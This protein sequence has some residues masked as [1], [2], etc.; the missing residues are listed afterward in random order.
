MVKKKRVSKLTEQE[1]IKNAKEYFWEQKKEE[2]GTFI[3]WLGVVLIFAFLFM[4]LIGMAGC[5]IAVG[6]NHPFLYPGQ[7]IDKYITAEDL[8]FGSVGYWDFF[9][10]GFLITMILTLLILLIVAICKSIGSWIDSNIETSFKRA[11]EDA[12]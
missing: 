10:I 9:G 12:E 7:G 3:S 2:I 8:R 5:T 4:P 6:I 1:I 11:L